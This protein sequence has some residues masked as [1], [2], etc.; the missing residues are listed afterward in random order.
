VWFTFISVDD[1]DGTMTRACDLGGE[2]GWVHTVPKHGRIGSIFDPGGACLIL[3]G[4][5]PAT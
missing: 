3:R 5:V 1:C 2:G 4:P